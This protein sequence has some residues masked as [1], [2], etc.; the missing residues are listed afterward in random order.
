MITLR[1]VYEGAVSGRSYS[2]LVDRL[3]PRGFRKEAAFWDEWN[4]EVAPDS[5]LRKWFHQDKEGRWTE[6]QHHYARE[7]SEKEGELKRL[8]NLEVKYGSLIL[9][10]AARNPDR[11]HA[12]VLKAVLDQMS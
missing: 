5:G 10:Y 8:K 4:K 6:F 3:W 2:V 9:V 7:L 12:L 1:R 11:N